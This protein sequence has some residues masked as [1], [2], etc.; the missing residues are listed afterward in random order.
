MVWRLKVN[1]VFYEVTLV[2]IAEQLG[3]DYIPSKEKIGAHRPLFNYYAAMR[4][5]VGPT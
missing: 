4:H 3:M 1:R 5:I 2:Q